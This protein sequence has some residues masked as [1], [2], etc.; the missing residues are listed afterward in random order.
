[1]PLVTWTRM[2]ARIASIIHCSSSAVSRPGKRIGSARG[3]GR[4]S[5]AAGKRLSTNESRHR[6]KGRAATREI[7]GWFAERLLV[8]WAAWDCFVDRLRERRKSFACASHQ[9]RG[10]NEAALRPRRKPSATDPAG[11]DREHHPSWVWRYVGCFTRLDRTAAVFKVASSNHGRADSPIARNS[12]DSR[13]L[14]VTVGVS[15]LSGSPLRCFPRLPGESGRC[16]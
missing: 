13:V 5:S 14:G 1:M 16:E 4:N 3:D 2:I 15:I 6:C 8:L 12:I 7:C 10:G 9:P 11:I